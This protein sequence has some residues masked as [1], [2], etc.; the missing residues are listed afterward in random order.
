MVNDIL[1]SSNEH[2]HEHDVDLGATAE[3]LSA[4]VPDDLAGQRI[5]KVLAQ[6][7]TRYSRSRLQNWL[8]KGR[9]LVNDRVAKLKEIAI[10]NTLITLNTEID[11]VLHAY[12][13]EPI[14]LD[15]VNEKKSYVVLNKPS[16]LVVHPAAG[17][18]SGTLLNGILFRYGKAAFQLPR[19]GIV[20]RLDKDTSGL[21]VVAR[22][23]SAQTT[24]V[25]Q[26][27][28]RVVK[29]CYLALV[30]GEP[31]AIGTINA[32]IGR[33]PRERTKMAVIDNDKGKPA[34]THFKV[35]AKGK[36]CNTTVSL[37]RC[38]LETGRTHQIRVHCEYS[39]FPIVGDPVYKKRITHSAD[40]VRKKIANQF[41]SNKHL[42]QM[43]SDLNQQNSLAPN[44]LTP[45]NDAA[46]SDTVLN[47]KRSNELL[48][49]RQALHAYQLGFA[50]PCTGENCY[51]QVMPPIDMIELLAACN[52]PIETLNQFS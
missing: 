8:E 3:I 13:A 5:D 46:V 22:T 48:F 36:W 12:R 37:L 31:P 17:N 16:N 52:I 9:V 49:N 6:L 21:M 51:W 18:W 2:E 28:A 35:L 24:L 34:V 47:N 45:F 38:D 30:W 11:L 7:F 41:S 50:D 1:L 44:L 25:K 39:G 4:N 26:L 32:P 19:A 14:N 27:Q 10:A 29:R 23:L 42:H 40:I 43:R 15:I 33:D 20:H